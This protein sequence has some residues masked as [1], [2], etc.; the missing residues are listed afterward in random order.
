MPFLRGESG[1]VIV[2]KLQMIGVER[3]KPVSYLMARISNALAHGNVSDV[4]YRVRC[5]TRD[6]QLV[7]LARMTFVQAMRRPE[8]RNIYFGM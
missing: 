1:L 4:A 7:D 3:R 6:D 8:T 5:S 2:E